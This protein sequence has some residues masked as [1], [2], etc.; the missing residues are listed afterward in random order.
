MV[1]AIYLTIK[2]MLNKLPSQSK[3]KAISE[4]RKEIEPL[5]Q[6]YC[7]LNDVCLPA[8]IKISDTEFMRTYEKEN[9]NRR[10]LPYGN[11]GG[12]AGQTQ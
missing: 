6:L 11:E 9:N 4:E 8:L 12:L 5:R 10:E 2:M 1:L 7:A 3:R